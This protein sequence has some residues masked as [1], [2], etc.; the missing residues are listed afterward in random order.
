MEISNN[1]KF[2]N[3]GPR[4]TPSLEAMGVLGHPTPQVTDFI[5]GSKVNRLL[6]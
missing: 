1:P 5:C 3:P 6:Q 2:L 4:L